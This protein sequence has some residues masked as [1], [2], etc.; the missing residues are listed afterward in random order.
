MKL[1]LIASALLYGLLSLPALAGTG[2]QPTCQVVPALPGS[3]TDLAGDAARTRLCGINFASANVAVCPKNW[4]TSAAALVY[5]VEGTQW[6]GNSGKFEAEVCSR[7]THAR[8]ASAGELAIFKHSM[9]DRETSGTYA[10]A[11]LLYDH[12]SR[13]LETEVNVPVA[14]E[15]QFPN[16]WYAT[17]VVQPG[18]ALAHS[19]RA[20]KML[21]AAWN[22]LD[23]AMGNP[24]SHPEAPELFLDDRQTLWGASLLFTGR[25]YGPEVNGTRESGWGAG[26]NHDFQHTAPFLLLRNPE[27]L[28]IAVSQAIEDARRDPTMA[29]ALRADTS[30]LQVMW[31]ANEVLEIVVLDYLLGQQDRVGNIDYETR[32]IW[33]DDGGLQSLPAH[34]ESAPHP[35]AQRLRVSWLNDNDAGLRASYANFAKQTAMLEE[36]R[37]FNPRLY[38]RLKELAADFRNRGP[39][40]QAVS[41]N[42]HL[43]SSEFSALAQRMQEVDS[44]ITRDCQAGRYRFDLDPRTFLPG[45]ERVTDDLACE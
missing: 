4:S 13:W 32:W 29:R 6:E 17:R 19:H 16:D 45:S 8:E 44:I 38:R 24:A 25:R 12:L 34:T 22:L 39:V 30:P 10:P 26:Q 11:A 3:P 2:S 15:Q 33:L 40:F 42:Y 9:N 36:L 27:P 18:L 43:R 20:S 5:D 41:S 21:I 7:G 28:E 14:V 31:W 35:N 1:T 37:H 23:E